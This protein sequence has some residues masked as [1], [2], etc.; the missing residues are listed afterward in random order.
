MAIP[1]PAS[2]RIEI[3]LAII[4]GISMFHL[5]RSRHKKLQMGWVPEQVQVSGIR[6]LI[7]AYLN[8]T[9]DQVRPMRLE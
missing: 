6:G 5:Q 9:R 7:I 3:D 8:E 1:R 4:A 2:E